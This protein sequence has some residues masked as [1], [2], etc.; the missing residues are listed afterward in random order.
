M[1]GAINTRTPSSAESEKNTLPFFS[2]KEAGMDKHGLYFYHSKP[3][4]DVVH[5][6]AQAQYWFLVS[7]YLR[8]ACLK[9]WSTNLVTFA[10]SWCPPMVIIIIHW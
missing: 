9:V 6:P 4:R 10:S 8:V 1:S 5:G 2:S 3:H 7:Q